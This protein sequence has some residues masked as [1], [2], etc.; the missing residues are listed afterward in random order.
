[1]QDRTFK[2]H[3]RVTR[4][5]FH[6]LCDQLRQHGLTDDNSTGGPARIPVQKKVVMVLWYLANQNCFRELADKFDVSQGAAHNVIMKML[7]R[8]CAIAEHHIVWPNDC[9]KAVQAA[10][11]KRLCGIDGIVG[12]I[13]G[14]HIRI[15]RPPVRGGDYLNRKAYY[16]VLLQGIVD[17]QGRFID[18]FA[19]PPGR[20][21]DARMLRLSPFFADHVQKLGDYKLLGDGAYLCNAFPFIVTPKR[22]NGALGEGDLRRNGMI[23]RG[24]VVV[25][26]AFGR[27]KCK[28]RRLR[29]IQ[30]CRVDVIVKIIVAACALHNFCI[31]ESEITCDE[32]PHGC[33]REGDD[34]E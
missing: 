10:L 26:Q 32:H 3:L 5:Q 28:W 9:Q 7:D 19:G 31:G 18:I 16:S 17:D 20:V 13:D 2:S 23:C 34:N 4:E 1:M 15:Q 6:L 24:R 30:N 33:P 14:C 11:F 25:E 29:D 27:L 21:H 12:A 8:I 22:D